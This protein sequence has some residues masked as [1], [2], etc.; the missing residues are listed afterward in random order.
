MQRLRID[1]F[2]RE[3]GEWLRSAF[4]SEPESKAYD[5]YAL[6]AISVKRADEALLAMIPQESY[7]TGAMG[8]TSYF[9]QVTI[10]LGSGDWWRDCVKRAGESRSNYDHITP[11]RWEGETIAEA[12]V[13]LGGEKDFSV[14]DIQVIAIRTRTFDSWSGD[15][16][17]TD[18]DNIVLYKAPKG[19]TVRAIVERFKN[20]EAR[21]VKAEC[22]F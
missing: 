8:E 3:F 4:S 22:D 2:I 9:Q 21:K 5:I 6:T 7:H 14:D 11:S 15:D 18:E 20:A 10:L 19:D 12:V 17:S 16:H 13:R 1:A